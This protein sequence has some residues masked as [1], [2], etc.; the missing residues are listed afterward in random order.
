M[1]YVHRVPEGYYGDAID[2]GDGRRWVRVAFPLETPVNGISV[3]ELWIKVATTIA[4]EGLVDNT[5]QFVPYVARGDRIR[6]GWTGDGPGRRRVFVEDLEE[7][8]LSVR[9][10]ADIEAEVAGLSDPP[11]TL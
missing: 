2:Q 1:T 7:P 3:E 10:W 11:P 6:F 5:P 8:H 9:S 4:L